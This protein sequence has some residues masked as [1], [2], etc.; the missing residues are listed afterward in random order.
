MSQL[1]LIALAL[2][3][4]L[5]ASLGR[6]VRAQV[7]GATAARPA[8]E[9]LD[10]TDEID[11]SVRWLRA[12]QAPDG[13]YGR[14]VKSSAWALQA[15]ALS[16][17]KY[18]RRD[19]PFV[20][21][22]LDY[23]SSKQDAESGG[24]Y[25]LGPDPGLHDIERTAQ[26]ALAWLALSL[27]HDDASAAV[28]IKLEKFFRTPLWPHSSKP[29]SPEEARIELAD[30]LGRRQPDGSWEGPEGALVRTAEG[31]IALTRCRQALDPG[32]ATPASATQL[33]KFDD[34]DRQQALASLH[35]GALFLVALSENGLWG[36]PGA[37]EL[38]LTAM[39]L[40][41]LQELPKPRPQDVQ[42][43]I[44]AGLD[45]LARHQDADGSIHDGKLKNYLTS[46]S[47]LALAKSG[48]VRFAPAIERAQRF[49]VALQADE[50]EGYTDGDLYYGGIG[51][52]G[53]ERPDLSNLQMALEALA[54][55]GTE[56]GDESFARALKFLERTQNRSESNDVALESDGA[57]IKS[58]N[59]GGAGYAPGDSKAGFETLADGSKVP[60][61]YGSMTYA[62]LK[63]FIFAGLPRDDPRMQAAW[64]WIREHYTLDVNPGFEHS[65]D[66]TAPYQGLYYYFH[67]MAKALDLYGEEEIVDG[68][69]RRHPWRQQLCGRLIAMQ[70]KDDGS[71]KNDNA[72]RWWEGNPILAT[73]YAML[74]LGSAL[75]RP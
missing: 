62:L 58:G 17:R 39:A 48:Q 33:P 37:P 23:L 14:S 69:G 71:W 28:R 50:G 15:L 74:T 1:R 44:D 34:A 70:R 12:Q 67:T 24:I 18:A 13:S 30:W 11:R 5:S 16:P 21:K 60:R 26:S 59:D 54:A 6:P 73:S 35:R 19:G 42:S 43:V 49:L 8:I 52:G 36:A 38:G 20:A 65:Q 64:K 27:Y 9:E 29:L 46:A 51:Y 22:A 2:L 47:V 68:A 55:A 7:P 3:L 41:A 40:G 31:I 75:P 4:L 72:P 66:P 53:D 56:K 32:Q 10:L 45:W 57:L 63:G 61:S 25:V